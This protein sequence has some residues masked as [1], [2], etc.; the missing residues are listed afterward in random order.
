MNLQIKN[1]FFTK[2]PCSENEKFVWFEQYKF[3]LV[4]LS[5]ARNILSVGSIS[6]FSGQ[7]QSKIYVDQS[8]YK[9][10]NASKMLQKKNMIQLI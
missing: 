1:F 2:S 4:N 9:L 7:I 6:Q 10:P 5:T 8:N 3:G